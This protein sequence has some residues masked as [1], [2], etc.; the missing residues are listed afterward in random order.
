MWY[1]QDMMNRD[2]FFSFLRF[3]LVVFCVVAGTTA[4]ARTASSGI[5]TES[6]SG[7]E[8]VSLE[9]VRLR[10][11]KAASD[12]T[13][14]EPQKKRLEELFGSSLKNLEKT[15]DWEAK[16]AEYTA[17]QASAPEIIS[18]LQAEIAG[19][20]GGIATE[21]LSHLDLN[22]LERALG[23]TDSEVKSVKAVLADLDKQ[24]A[25]MSGRRIEAPKALADA[26][27]RREA[28][29]HSAVE[30]A[31][32]S[33]PELQEA[34]AWW[35]SSQR[36][37]ADAEVAA[38]ERE[39]ETFDDRL[40]TRKV[41]REHASRK[42]V[43]LEA[44]L[45]YV[46]DKVN[47][48]RR[49]EA[50]EAARAARAAL[51][52][53]ADSCPVVQG[54]ARENAE[55]TGTRAAL[56]GRLA[57]LAAGLETQSRLL[58]KIRDDFKGIQD[59]IKTTG[60]TD[61]IG[62]LLRMKRSELPEASALSA[63]VRSRRALISRVQEEML[64]L[65]ERILR[66]QDLAGL[67]EELLRRVDPA[68][69]GEQMVLIRKSIHGLLKAQKE[70]LETFSRDLTAYFNMLVDLDSAEAQLITISSDYTT[71]IDER[72]LWI[73]SCRGFGRGDLYRSLQGAW[74]LISPGNLMA[75]GKSFRDGLLV[76]YPL[77]FS[78]ALCLLAI[79][80][81][82]RKLFG[83]M[84]AIA[85]SVPRAVS[86]RF[87]FTLKAFLITFI[88]SGFRP[89]VLLVVSQVFQSD[90]AV[91]EHAR[92]VSAALLVI[93]WVWLFWEFLFHVFLPKGLADIHFQWRPREVYEEIRDR[94][95]RLIRWLLP[96]LFLAQVFQF[97]GNEKFRESIGRLVFVIG[98]L[99]LARLAH[100]LFF[101]PRST[102]SQVY[103]FYRS[104]LIFK[105]RYVTYFLT[106]VMPVVL[107]VA[108]M[109][110]YYYTS[111]RLMISSFQTL[112]LF[113][114]VLFLYSLSFRALQVQRR[115]LALQKVQEKRQEEE[116]AAEEHA[117]A[118]ASGQEDA[119]IG[120]RIGLTAHPEPNIHTMGQQIQK[121]LLSVAIILLLIG[122]WVI[123]EETLPAIRILDRVKLWS[124]TIKVSQEV[125]SPDGVV[126][127]QFL[128]KAG[129]ISLMD[130]IVAIGLALL[131]IIGSRN[132]PGFIEF[133]VLQRLPLDGGVRYA[134]RT[135]TSYAIT[136]VG[137]ILVFQILG[138]GWEKVQWLAA[139]MSVGL[140]FGL[141]EIF[142][143]FVAGLILLFERP[144]R[145]GDVVTVGD[146]SGTVSKIEIRATTLIDW[147]RKELII[148]NR[149]FI[150]GKLMNWTLSD[151]IQ[152]VIFPVGVAYGTDPDKVSRLLMRVAEECVLVLREPPP[153][154]IF[155]SFGDSSLNF[156]LRLFIP[157]LDNYQ[158]LLTQINTSINRA[159]AEGG[160]EIPFPQRDLHVRSIPEQWRVPKP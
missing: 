137:I 125:L 157:N 142:A 94:I 23:K 113:V 1:V 13:L 87:N 130:L 149:E 62:I 76:N 58:K 28:L 7:P 29:V 61:S 69:S 66:L 32:E 27:Q 83:T 82:R 148:P 131:T 95:C 151:S 22:D 25:E 20:S 35:Q 141:Q 100:E 53:A 119:D 118:T 89:L 103:E 15:R 43:F 17:R 155:R 10:L 18:S 48:R 37:M 63:G 75:L 156:E 117:A 136:I 111:Q 39:L 104:K 92:A 108:T 78:L 154:A 54:L 74:W 114:G 145:V 160:V 138:I 57:D 11:E 147:D 2:R 150:T 84:E 68:T 49:Q 34:A 65:D 110:G 9:G 98:L 19:L 88:M 146:S 158:D 44:Q 127:Q 60:F 41:R 121:L 107:A 42:L 52:G 128:E 102:F 134:V 12:K 31:P 101:P 56:T 4:M 90:A 152:R 140:G 64:E 96:I 71:F 126:Q 50:D 55:I 6:F 122:S 129:T 91:G 143:N 40:E 38:L 70:F 30:A 67:E 3:W 135:L 16:V 33:V 26:R 153:K 133:A 79:F 86:D 93:A 8:D 144:I 116:Q 73:K 124:T 5:L 14:P 112:F 115:T 132:L 85:E 72:V 21:A 59:R 139:G 36:K 47:D 80:R 105:L 120:V 77:W 51:G 24:L 106:A 45:Q 81:L 99:I 46:Q 159:L 97:Q 109:T 123:W